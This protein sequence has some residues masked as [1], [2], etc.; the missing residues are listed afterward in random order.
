MED[1]RRPGEVFKMETDD[2]FWWNDSE[3]VWVTAEKAG[4][5]TATMFWPGSN[6]AYGGE[7]ATEWPNKITGEHPGPRAGSS[8]TC[9]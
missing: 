4:I 6:V 1:S 2:P 3:P 8:S 5:R 7:R 9:R